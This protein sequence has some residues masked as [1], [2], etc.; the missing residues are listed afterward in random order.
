VTK[1]LIVDDYVFWHKQIRLELKGKPITLIPARSMA[2]A[3]RRL[4]ENPD[5][6]VIA[7]DDCIDSQ[8]PNTLDF[9]RKVKKTFKG[10]MIAFT[11]NCNNGSLL[12]EAGC[13]FQVI[14]SRLAETLLEILCPLEVSTR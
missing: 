6:E 4:N 13:K 11:S 12:I 2:Q 14:K 8:N 10:T 7:V 9:V 1:V 3:L 5:I